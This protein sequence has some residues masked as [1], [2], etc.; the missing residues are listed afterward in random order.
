M[1]FYTNVCVWGG[2]ILYR[3]IENGRRVS[4]KLDYYPSLFLIDHNSS[5]YRTIHGQ[6]LKRIQVGDI[7]ATREFVKSHDGIDNSP[8]YGNQRY[9]Y[10]WIA[11]QYPDDIEWD[12]SQ[13]GRAHV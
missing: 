8:V 12:I 6:R 7:R 2:K 1:H 5:V 3:G 9:E 10:C 11:D 4:D 13:I